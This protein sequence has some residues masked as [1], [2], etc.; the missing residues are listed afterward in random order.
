MRK[1]EGAQNKGGQGGHE[2]EHIWKKEIK[3]KRDYLGGK[4]GQRENKLHLW[5][6]VQYNKIKSSNTK[7]VT[8]SK[9]NKSFSLL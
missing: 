5:K 6:W 9:D 7:F 3:I 8:I 1:V 2:R 4:M